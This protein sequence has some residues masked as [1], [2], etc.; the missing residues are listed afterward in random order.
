MFLALFLAAAL[1]ASATPAPTPTASPTPRYSLDGAFSGYASSA[2]DVS[3]ALLTV[4]KNADELRFTITGGAYAFP[5]VGQPLLATIGQGANTDLYGALPAYALEFV[6]NGHV[7]LSA[8]QLP[9]LMGQ[10]S[11]FTFQNINVQRG[12]I[13]AA[14]TTFSRGVRV[15]YANNKINLTLGYDDGYYSGNHG[16]ALEGLA[17]WSPTANTSWQFG[18]TLP[19]A[20]TPGNATSS[21]AN[22]REYDLML[23]QQYGK[24]QLLPYVLV[25]SSPASLAQ[26]YAKAESATGLA[27]LA[28]Y[29]ANGAYSVAFR[30]ESFSNASAVSDASANAD[31]V[32]YGAGSKVT[33]WTLTPTWHP[34]PFFARI[35]LSRVTVQNAPSNNQSRILGELGVQ[36]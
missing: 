31:L 20:N 1:D 10:E 4:T 16:R 13:W 12:L 15:L 36:F 5:T 29:V 21:V 35:D 30:L 28:N 14:E 26:G 17:A 3:N 25:V 7:T 8:G 2:T 24:L 27:L 11:G 34:G 22:K 9:S 19:G 32:G 18:F 6:P 33:T 23:T